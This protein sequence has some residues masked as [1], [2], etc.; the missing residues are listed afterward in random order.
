MS[1]DFHVYLSFAI[2][3]DE[4]VYQMLDI[5]Y[6]TIYNNDERSAFYDTDKL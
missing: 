2:F 5:V 3:A 1:G 4:Y 6:S